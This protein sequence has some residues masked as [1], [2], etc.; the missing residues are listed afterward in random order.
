MTEKQLKYLF[1]IQMALDEIDLYLL[2]KGRDFNRFKADTMFRRAIERDLEI[3][4][5]AMNR[6]IKSSFE[7][8]IENAKGI[9]A[10]R[11]KVIHEYDA[12]SPENIWSIVINHL[13]KLKVEVNL[14][15]K[16]NLTT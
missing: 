8:Q 3:V 11:N 4:G 12:I 15:I 13:P 2:E 10:L 14:L 16:S 6:L 9:V 1:D 5:E 7:P